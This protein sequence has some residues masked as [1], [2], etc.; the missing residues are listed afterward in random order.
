MRPDRRGSLALLDALLFLTVVSAA[1]ALLLSDLAPRAVDVRGD[2]ERYAR[3]V[4]QTSLATT[5]EGALI[6]AHGQL[7]LLDPGPLAEILADALAR[8]G[9]VN[10]LPLLWKVTASL[11]PLVR[12]DWG[13]LFTAAVTSETGPRQHL[14]AVGHVPFPAGGDNFAATARFP[15]ADG[16]SS[17]LDVALRLYPRT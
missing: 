8:P 10:V 6:L 17:V 9:R 15:L 11:N 13:Y 4:L 16:D 3:A 1:S 7:I 5:V 12:E 14:T 2:G